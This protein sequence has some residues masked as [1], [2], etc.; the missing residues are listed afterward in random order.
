M[1]PWG[2]PTSTTPGVGQEAG[3]P[4]GSGVR[5][6]TEHTQAHRRTDSHLPLA[7]RSYFP[8]FPFPAPQGALRSF[9]GLLAFFLLAPDQIDD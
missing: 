1:G 8:A 3:G 5:D 9:L 7:P 2:L 6:D 4:C